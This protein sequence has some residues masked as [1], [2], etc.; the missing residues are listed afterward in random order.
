MK[1]LFLMLVTVLLILAACG[2]TEWDLNSDKLHGDKSG[3]RVVAKLPSPFTP[4]ILPGDADPSSKSYTV[5][6][7]VTIAGSQDIVNTITATYDSTQS[8]FEIGSIY[9]LKG[10][11]Y[12]LYVLFYDPTETP[13]YEVGSETGMAR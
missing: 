10:I 5:K 8:T 11:P 12:D 9:L 4:S 7:I 1:K 6:T 3:V 2:P 13:S